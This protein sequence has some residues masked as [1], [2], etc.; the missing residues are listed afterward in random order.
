MWAAGSGQANARVL[1]AYDGAAMLNPAYPL[2]VWKALKFLFIAPLILLLCLVINWMTYQGHW[3]VQ[4][5]A[6]GI[7]IAWFI[8]LMRVIKATILVGGAAALVN[9]LTKQKQDA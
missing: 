4:W 7:G 1:T 6:L 2:Q 8:C 3:W 5:A 9:W